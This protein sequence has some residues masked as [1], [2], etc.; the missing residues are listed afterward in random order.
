VTTGCGSDL[1]RA[2]QIAY[3]YNKNYGMNPKVGLL[4]QPEGDEE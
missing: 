1:S 2:T 4:S 3:E